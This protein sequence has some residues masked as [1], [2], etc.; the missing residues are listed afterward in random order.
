MRSI[1]VTSKNR[2]KVEL[3]VGWN[4]VRITAPH[5]LELNLAPRF[6]G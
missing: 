3:F 6:R 5:Q 4:S 2:L 1:L